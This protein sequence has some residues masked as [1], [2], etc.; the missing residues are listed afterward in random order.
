[1]S[2]VLAETTQL[3]KLFQILTTLRS[4]QFLVW[5]RFLIKPDLFDNNVPLDNTT[6][7]YLINLLWKLGLGLG[8][9]LDLHY[10]RIFRRAE[11][12]EYEH[13][14]FHEFYV[15]GTRA[16]NNTK[17]ITYSIHILFEVAVGRYQCKAR[18]RL[19]INSN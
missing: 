7:I 1:V 16:I 12:N 15:T 14:I 2:V 19:P 8:L 18:M 4:C 17:K 3:G 6:P 9:D 10:F 13:L 11:N 5:V